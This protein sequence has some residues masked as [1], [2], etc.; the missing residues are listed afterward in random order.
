MKSLK[1]FQLENNALTLENMSQVFGGVHATTWSN[2]SSNQ[3]GE[4]TYDPNWMTTLE[5]DYRITTR[6]DWIR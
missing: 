1:E 3:C 4:D 6:R 5:R 2:T